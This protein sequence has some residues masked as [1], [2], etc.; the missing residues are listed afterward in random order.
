MTDRSSDTSHCSGQC[1]HWSCRL[2]PASWRHFV[3]LLTAAVHA[4]DHI[5]HTH[6]NTHVADIFA[7]TSSSVDFRRVA[8]RKRL[9]SRVT[10]NAWYRGYCPHSGL[11]VSKIA[12]L[13]CLCCNAGPSFRRRQ[14]FIYRSIVSKCFSMAPHIRSHRA[15]K[16]SMHCPHSVM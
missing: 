13:Y 14:S 11:A 8:H 3:V 9:I 15:P 5:S 16:Q 1:C 12:T 7:R 10:F 6:A 4:A 2:T